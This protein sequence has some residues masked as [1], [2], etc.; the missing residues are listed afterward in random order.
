MYYP[1]SVRLCYNRCR[2]MECEYHG[3]ISRNAKYFM[4]W[5]NETGKHCGFV[6]ST[7]DKYLGRKNLVSLGMSTSETL[8]FEQYCKETVDS[9]EPISW[10]G[11]L[12]ARGMSPTE[13]LPPDPAETPHIRE[14]R[15]NIAECTDGR[16]RRR[17][18]RN[19]ERM[20][21]EQRRLQQ[22]PA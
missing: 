10:K 2:M 12:E 7:H 1:W 13:L 9:P 16:I 18:T 6:C 11:W 20:L 19:L 4:C 8:L 15:Q 5:T 17:L 14:L 3:C 21:D 22:T